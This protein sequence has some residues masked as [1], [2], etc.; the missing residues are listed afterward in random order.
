MRLER[1]ALMDDAK[2]ALSDLLAYAIVHTDN[3]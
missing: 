3:A 2:R 1:L